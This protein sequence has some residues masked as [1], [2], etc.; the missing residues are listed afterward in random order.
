MLK[1]GNSSTGT[2]SKA[3]TS[4]ISWREDVMWEP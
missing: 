2:G 3:F 1:Y 4:K